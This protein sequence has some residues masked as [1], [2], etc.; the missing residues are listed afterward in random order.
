VN[1]NRMTGLLRMS[2]R[3]IT[4]KQVDWDYDWIEK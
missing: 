4:L 3:S 2:L 1:A